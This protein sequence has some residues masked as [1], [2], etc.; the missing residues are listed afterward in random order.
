M[1]IMGA[2]P[3][4]MLTLDTNK[5]P[6]PMI[7]E[8]IS[9]IMSDMTAVGKSGN[10][11]QQNWKYR[12]IDDLKNASNPI[13]TKHKVFYSPEILEHTKTE[14]D[15]KNGG[16]QIHH[17]M[18][19][20]YRLYTT[21]GSFVEATVIG[22][23]MDSGDKG[24]GKAQT[25][26]EKVMLIQVLNIP[27]EEQAKS[28]PDSDEHEITNGENAETADQKDSDKVTEPPSLGKM[29]ANYGLLKEKT[30]SQCTEKEL[31]DQMEWIE[32]NKKGHTEKAKQFINE[33]N[34]WIAHITSKSDKEPPDNIGDEMDIP[35]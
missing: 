17:E 27:T 7:Y 18:K 23:A 20:K 1:N 32:K 8:K 25:Y 19:I 6:S 22:E 14:R 15:T 5:T 34:L 3:P 31:M 21:D 16:K 24:A 12:K 26:A 29:K 10:N 9:L 2:M 4:H 13:F 33:A 35:F 28:D 11:Q 30:Y